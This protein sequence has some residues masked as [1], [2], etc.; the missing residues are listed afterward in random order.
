LNNRKIKKRFIVA[1]VE[2]KNVYHPTL[3]LGLNSIRLTIYQ[4]ILDENL[5]FQERTTFQTLVSD[6]E[7]TAY[8]SNVVDI[9]DV[10]E[11]FAKFSVVNKLISYSLKV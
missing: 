7:S 9:N 8:S 5:I 4:V 3:I 10:C 11:T 2:A 6:E 1:V